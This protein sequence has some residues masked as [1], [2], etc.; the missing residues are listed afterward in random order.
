M[1]PRPRKKIEE[2][3]YPVTLRLPLYLI[4]KIKEQGG[5]TAIIEK[6]VKEYLKRQ[7]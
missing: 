6:A 7:K 3:R 2:K 5:L 4:E 1:M